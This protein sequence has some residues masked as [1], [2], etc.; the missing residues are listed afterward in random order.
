MLHSVVQGST[1]L[2]ETQEDINAWALD[3]SMFSD[4]S[5]VKVRTSV[6]GKGY[7]NRLKL[8]S[9]NETDYELLS[10]CWVFKYK[11]LR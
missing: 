5:L 2:G 8:I 1:I 6:S 11:N 4:S 3:K 9:T 7:H 10:L